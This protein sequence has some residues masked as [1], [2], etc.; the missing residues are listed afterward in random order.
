MQTIF[1]NLPDPTFEALLEKEPV[2]IAEVARGGYYADREVP[3]SF[4]R[5]MSRE[6]F[7]K[8]LELI[9]K[10]RALHIRGG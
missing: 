7:G 10:G 5:G 3:D 1:P 8:A 4:A 2:A 9:K 6:D